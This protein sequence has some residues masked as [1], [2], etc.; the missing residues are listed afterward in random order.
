MSEH[1]FGESPVIDEDATSASE[2]QY[3]ETVVEYVDNQRRRVVLGALIAVLVLLV[4]LLAGAAYAVLY[5]SRGSGGPAASDLPEGIEWVRSIYGWGDTLEESLAAPV[6]VAVAPDGSIWTVSGAQ[7]I[8]GFNPDGSL[9]KLIRPERGFGDGQ[10][11]TLEG[12]DVGPDGTIYLA[13]QGKGSI[14]R[15]SQ[16]GTWIGNWPVALPIELAAGEDDK[17][18]VTGEGSFGLL[19]MEG[20]N[21]RVLGQWGQRGKGEEDLDL[22]HGIAFGDNGVV[23]VSD[24]HNARVKAYDETGTIVWATGGNPRGFQQSLE[25]TAAGPFQLPSGMTT[26]GNKRVVVVD[27]FEFD[28]T[29]LD[30]KSGKVLGTYG[31]D[32]EADGYFGYPTGIDYDSTR[33]W[34]VV[35]DTANNRLQILR[36]PGSGGSPVAALRRAL[37]GPAWV[38]CIPLFLLLVALIAVALRRRA[39]SAE[40]GPEGVSD[41]REGAPEL[42]G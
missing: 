1:D 4:I 7:V 22:P 8:V 41:G 9:K 17:L 10:V 31:E 2:P 11:S 3:T 40:Q 16:D 35:A 25:Q 32:G 14:E 42:A 23:F 33:D 6:D 20:E 30:P 21:A 36:I 19:S 37:V 38:C 13:D 18:A 29:V 24:T 15:F 28:I 39:Q 12:I 26:D 27:P 34:F 5:F